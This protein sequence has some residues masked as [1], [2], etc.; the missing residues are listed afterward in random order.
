MRKMH[1][2]N[3]PSAEVAKIAK[4]G[5]RNLYFTPNESSE[6]ANL[7]NAYTNDP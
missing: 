7:E 4:N 5:P 6:Q 2:V 3:A 1:H